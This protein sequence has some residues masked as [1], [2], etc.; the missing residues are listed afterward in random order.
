MKVTK[1]D[2]GWQPPTGISPRPM[3][4]GAPRNALRAFNAGVI[5][6]F[7]AQNLPAK[8]V[9]FMPSSFLLGRRQLHEFLH[10]LPEPREAV[11]FP[12]CLYPD[13]DGWFCALFGKKFQK[14]SNDIKSRWKT[15][16]RQKNTA[17]I[18]HRKPKVYGQKS[19]KGS[20]E[21]IPFSVL[22]P[23]YGTYGQR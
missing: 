22:P 4:M 6:G 7:F 5:A 13:W 15:E 18:P 1:P 10:L 12:L 2:G 21:V 8:A 20:A 14:I 19:A 9:E 11:Y 17:P 23:N 3:L 16:I